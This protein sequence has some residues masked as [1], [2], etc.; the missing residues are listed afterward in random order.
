MVRIAKEVA[1]FVALPLHLPSALD[2]E[3]TVQHYVYLKP[4]DPKVADEDASRSLFLV[5]IPV[6]TTE[7]DLKHLFTTQLQG[8]RVDHI[9]FSE[10]RPGR[11]AVATTKGSRSSRKRKRMTAEEIE[12][13]LDS[14]S[15][16]EVWSSELHT[17]GATAIIV[18]V[19]RPS[20]ELSLKNAKRAVKTGQKVIWREGLHSA[21]Y[22]GLRRYQQYNELHFPPRRDL[23]RSVD[24]YMSAY[25]QMEEARS[26]ENAKKRQMPDEDGFVTV[27]RGP[28]AGFATEQAKEQVEKKKAKDEG[29]ADF[30]RFQM[31]ERRREQHD[32]MLK[33]F[34]DDKRRVAEMRAK[35]AAG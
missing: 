4:H 15:L 33:K 3:E 18:F 29:L 9:Y 8:G 30:Y 7:D 2:G 25:A 14:Y 32:T 26:Q 12:G 19:D 16:P 34:D 13:G 27:T 24:G 17:S 1:G 35:R 6:T 31:R 21:E 10:D 28:K 5:N 11:T 20:M 22:L 23:L